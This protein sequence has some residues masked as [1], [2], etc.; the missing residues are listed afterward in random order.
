VVL[1]A[2]YLGTGDKEKS[3]VAAI[4]KNLANNQELRYSTFSHLR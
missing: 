4:E 3:L 1:S 2:L